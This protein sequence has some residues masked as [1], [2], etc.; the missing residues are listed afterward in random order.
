MNPTPSPEDFSSAPTPAPLAASSSGEGIAERY[1]LS[2]LQKA[3]KILRLTQ[4]VSV[5]AVLALAIYMGIMTSKVTNFA[6][7]AVAADIANGLISERV[8]DSASAAAEQFKQQLPVVMAQLPDQA[9]EQMPSFRESLEA[10]VEEDLR[11]YST[12]SSEEMGK[13]LDHFLDSHKDQIG[14]VMEVGGDRKALQAMGPDL[15]KEM[16][17]YLEVAPAGG[18]ESIKTKLDKSLEMLRVVKAKTN[19]LASAKDLTT[20]ELKARRAIAIISRT[21]HRELKGV[22]VQKAIADHVQPVS[23]TTN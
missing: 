15:E 12:Q 2:E 22:D 6:Q 11:S 8:S 17:S 13:N 9:I 19:R 20:E 1:V 3:R 21:A 7:P 5:L 14:T 10:K 16:M 4:I 23:T 18:G